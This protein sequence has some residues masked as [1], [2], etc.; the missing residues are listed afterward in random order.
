MGHWPKSGACALA[1]AC[2]APVCATADLAPA[3]GARERDMMEQIRAAGFACDRP[4]RV[5]RDDSERGAVLGLGGLI[6]KR[7]RCAGKS[8]L[9]ATPDP[10]RNYGSR[11]TPAT[12]IEPAP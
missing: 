4:V 3:P 5:G 8:Y 10:R 2:L 12:V 9:V 7:V 6:V 1:L 11:P